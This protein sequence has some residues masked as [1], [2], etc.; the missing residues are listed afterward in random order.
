MITQTVVPVEVE[1]VLSDAYP[2]I[3]AVQPADLAYTLNALS[4]ALEGRGADLGANLVKL[5]G[6]LQQVNPS[7]P[8]AVSDLT[9]LDRVADLYRG[10]C[11]TSR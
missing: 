8:Q 2:L 11:P 3:T 9:K 7:Y 5:D 1:Q 10:C 4:T 6:L